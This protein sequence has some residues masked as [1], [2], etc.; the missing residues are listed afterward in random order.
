MNYWLLKTEPGEFSIDDLQK[1]EIS[2]WDGVRN[3][4]ARNIMRDRMKEGDLVLIYH[5]VK[6]PAIVGLAEV[7]GGVA[8]D[9]TQFDP[10]NKH[11]DPKSHPASP[12]WQMISVK[13]LKKFKK[14]LALKEIKE[15]PQ[16]A[17]MVLLKR[18]RLSVQPVTGSE[19]MFIH[20]L[21]T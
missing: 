14:S 7:V 16:L 13:F 6:N 3:Y 11:Y 8:D 4:E 5:S 18:G 10:L 21:L 12:R 15:I 2:P 9:H 19:F 20:A 17:E 1:M